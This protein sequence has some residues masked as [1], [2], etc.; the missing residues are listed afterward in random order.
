MIAYLSVER[1][2]VHLHTR[3]AMSAHA[4]GVFASLKFSSPCGRENLRHFFFLDA[5]WSA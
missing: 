3:N 2:R 5:R 4:A 1:V